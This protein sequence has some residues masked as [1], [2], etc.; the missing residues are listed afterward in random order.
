MKV[1]II[2]GRDV[3]PTK[4]FDAFFTGVIVQKTTAAHADAPTP[5]SGPSLPPAA[6]VSQA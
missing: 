6:S 2:S 3:N 1:P 4:T 5:D